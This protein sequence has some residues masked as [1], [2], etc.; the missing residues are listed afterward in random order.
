[1]CIDLAFLADCGWIFAQHFCNRIGPAYLQLRNILDQSNLAHAEVL[2]DIK[3]QFHEETFTR[4]SIW[5][6]IHAHPE[7]GKLHIE[8]SKMT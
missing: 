6:V 5:Q 1:M 4:E 2:N 3:R 7:L 8:V